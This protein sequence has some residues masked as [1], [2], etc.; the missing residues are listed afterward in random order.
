MA[1]SSRSHMYIQKQDGSWYEQELPERSW[2][3]QL[4]SARLGHIT[5]PSG[6]GMPDLV[7]TTG[8]YSGQVRH[9]MWILKSIPDPPFFD[10]E[11]PY[12]GERLPRMGLDLE[13]LDVNNDGY[14]DIYVVQQFDTDCEK[15]Y[16]KTPVVDRGRDLLYVSKPGP[17]GKIKLDKVYM[18]NELRGCGGFI[19]RYGNDQTAVLA[20]GNHEHCGFHY[21]LEWD[22]QPSPAPTPAAP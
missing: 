21:L 15:N 1:W 16:E 14:K 7:I 3:T 19:K 8:S 10:F 22:I 12:T 17:D 18:E 11:F 9:M 6:G 2:T 13:I 20:N 5:D 4:Q